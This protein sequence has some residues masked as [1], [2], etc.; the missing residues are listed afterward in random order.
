MSILQ[1][2]VVVL[3]V[4]NCQLQKSENNDVAKSTEGIHTQSHHLPICEFEIGLPDLK[5][6]TR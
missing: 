2:S 6:K 1:S 5:T 3:I 4:L